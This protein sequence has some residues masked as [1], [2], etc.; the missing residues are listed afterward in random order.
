MRSPDNDRGGR[1]L[2]GGSRRLQ[3]SAFRMDDPPV[4][5]DAI[6]TDR[7][8]HVLVWRKLGLRDAAEGGFRSVSSQVGDGARLGTDQRDH[9]PVLAPQDRPVIVPAGPRTGTRDLGRH[10]E[11]TA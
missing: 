4:P 8:V 5:F 3:K 10:S 9:R 1:L 7:L 2:R 6:K 11:E